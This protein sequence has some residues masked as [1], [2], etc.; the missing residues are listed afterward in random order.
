VAGVSS[1][2]S[3]GGHDGRCNFEVQSLKDRF[4]RGD[5]ARA[6][7]EAGWNLNELRPAAMSLEEVFLQLTGSTDTK[8]EPTEV[9]Q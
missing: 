8:T 7:V 6:V 1:V 3:R 2:I 4:I 5:L 9:V